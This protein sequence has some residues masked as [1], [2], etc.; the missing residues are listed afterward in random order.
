V[1]EGELQ[2]T[3]TLNGT[4]TVMGTTPRG[5]IGGELALLYNAPSLVSARA[6]MPSRLMIFDKSCFR[7][8]FADAPTVG[9]R[10][11][12]IAAERT[13]NF[14][15]AVKQQE[16]LAALG[17]LSAGL[18]HELNNPA[19]ATRRAADT[20][21]ELL[22]ELQIQTLKLNTLGLADDEIQCLIEYQHKATVRAGDTPLLTALQRSEREDEVS[23]WLDEHDVPGGWKMASTFVEMGFTP[24]YQTWQR[25]CQRKAC[26][27]SWGG[28]T[29]RWARRP[30]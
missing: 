3:R 1:L 5:I 26:R 12:Q 25:T 18:A 24:S 14:A 29:A 8:I 20:L 16:K 23:D 30:C 27:L 19:S 17:K 4:P 9:A 22:P 2:V 7:Q 11:F 28:C 21:R 10:I 13:Q 6:I 15:A